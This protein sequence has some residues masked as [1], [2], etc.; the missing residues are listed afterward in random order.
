MIGAIE[1]F[2]PSTMGSMRD[3]RLPAVAATVAGT[4]DQAPAAPRADGA[5]LDAEEHLPT[6][7]AR[8][9]EVVM[10]MWRE[11]ER[12]E[13]SRESLPPTGS[14]KPGVA[15]VPAAAPKPIAPEVVASELPGKRAE[16]ETQLNRRV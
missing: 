12:P 9:S 16:A 14:L 3:V 1:G 13:V 8:F 5:L 2:Q 7:I 15:A 10:R 11:I 4:R 6:S